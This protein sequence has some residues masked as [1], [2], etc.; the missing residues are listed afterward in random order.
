[1]YTPIVCASLLL[2]AFAAPAMWKDSSAPAIY[3]IVIHEIMPKPAPVAGLPPYEYVELRNRSS[4][5]VQLQN[6]RLGVNKREAVLPAYLLQPGGLLLLCAPAAVSSY[7]ITNIVGV[8]RFPALADDSGLVTL[9]NENKNVIHAVAYNKSWYANT[10]KDKG[11]FSLEM[12]DAACPCCGKINWCASLSATGGTPGTYNA[13]AAI[14]TDFSRPDLYY[15]A[16]ADS[17]HIILHFSKTVDSLVAADPAHYQLSDGS[18]TAVT[19]TPPLFNTVTLQLS[20]ALQ[21][22]RVYNVT[23]T[24]V[25]SCGGPESGLKNT[26]AFGLPQLPEASDLVINEVLFNPPPGIPKFIELYNRSNKVIDLQQVRICARKAA[27]NLDIIKN[28]APEGHILLPGQLLA[29]T[30]YADLLCAYYTCKSLESIAEVSSLPT[31]PVEEGTVVLLRADSL[32][33]DEVPYTI[34]L[35][36][37]LASQLKG[38]S[39]ERLDYNRPATDTDNWQSAAATAGYATPGYPNSQQWAAPETGVNISLAPAIFSPDND[40]VD[41]Q[42]VLSYLLPEPGWIGNVTVYNAS[43]RPVRYLARNIL[44]GNKG[45]VNWDGFGENTVVLPAGIYIFFI[46]IFNLKGQVKRW[47]HALV[48]AR[49]LN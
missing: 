5:P 46:E 35:H 22:D 16:V 41:D 29:L 4:K 19:V 20:A 26:A 1:M 17:Q 27:G 8:D 18:V 34:S 38:V 23:V 15:V 12:I 14:T 2:Q 13:A 47:K 9:Y 10:S 7:P 37:R 24:G 21:P 43:G 30:T 48:M 40:G 39:L 44:L 25:T 28:I 32:V 36:F 6:W 11:G 3:D 49:K 33:L 31:M 42:A 45:V